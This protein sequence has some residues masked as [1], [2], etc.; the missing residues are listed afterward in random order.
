[1]KAK[2]TWIA[3]KPPSIHVIGHVMFGGDKRTVVLTLPDNDIAFMDD[4]PPPY[5]KGKTWVVLVGGEPLV[6]AKLL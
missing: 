1:M 5:K 6:K 2:F 3:K 4:N